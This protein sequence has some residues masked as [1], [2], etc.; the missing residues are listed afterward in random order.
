VLGIYFC[1]IENIFK[2]WRKFIYFILV[3]VALVD[4]V[5]CV[6]FGKYIWCIYYTN[7]ST[8]S[9]LSNVGGFLSGT[10]GILTSFLVILIVLATFIEQKRANQK[11]SAENIFF[12][13]V[14]SYDDIVHSMD[15]RNVSSENPELCRGRN[16]F[17]AMYK[18]FTVDEKTVRGLKMLGD[19]LKMSKK[20]DEKMFKA[21]DEMYSDFDKNYQ[22]YI[23][24]YFRNLYYLIRFVDGSN[25]ITDAEK[26]FYLELLR[27]KI[28]SFELL[29]LFYDGLS[30]RGRKNFKPLLE[31]YH[32][33]KH[34]KLVKDKLLD[35]NHMNLYSSSAFEE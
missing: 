24:Y 12:Q 28:S 25:V 1:K 10:V 8:L 6:L 22:P 11:Q 4:V 16:A 15:V 7:T 35:Q 5:L 30:M 23:G 13:L 3:S 14:D 9:N 26:F 32:M 29:L 27:A 17:E 31:R 2:M 21:V 33:L 34:I 19:L 20:F 18:E